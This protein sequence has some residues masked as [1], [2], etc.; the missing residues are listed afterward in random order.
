M[1]GIYYFSDAMKE[2]RNRKKI[3]QDK[4]AENL[5][6]SRISINN[7]E[8]SR[9]IPNL[10]TAIRIAIY[11][12]ISLDSVIEKTKSNRLV[13]Q[14][15]NLEDK[16]LSKCLRK[17]LKKITRSKIMNELFMAF[18]ALGL[19]FFMGAVG[20]IMLYFTIRVVKFIID[21][22]ESKIGEM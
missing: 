5:K 10:D 18:F 1:S 19:L 12:D 21:F 15:D 9:Q 8:Q 7:Y 16:E 2:A 11:L 14:I 22:I 6:I 20:A 17:S 13:T 4:L 3:S